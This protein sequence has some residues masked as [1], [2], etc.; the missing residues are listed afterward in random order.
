MK[1]LIICGSPR[2]NG[3]TE[4]LLSIFAKEL[5]DHNVSTKMITL[6]NKNIKHCR[7]CD[8]CTGI[9]RC[10]QDDDF[11]II[12]DLALKNKGLV[13][14]SPVYVGTPTSL[15]LAFLQ[16]MTYVSFNNNQPLAKKIGGPITV[17][18]ETGH[19]TTLNNLV[20]FYLVNEMII[21]GS[22]YWNIGNGVNKGDI[23]SDKKGISYITR[24]AENMAW[25][26]K[27]C[28]GGL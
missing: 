2:R 22:N 10:I 5:I 19:L 3:N 28:E 26:M 23:L 18:G 24:F 1:T 11:N 17:A 21:P 8:K 27:K 25:M 13:I 20:D 15:I 4:K 6:A 9:N 14:G 16:R 7:H 12:Y